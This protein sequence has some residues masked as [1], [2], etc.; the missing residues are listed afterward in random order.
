MQGAALGVVL[1][2]FVFALARMLDTGGSVIAAFLPVGLFI[3]VGIMVLN[4]IGWP[5]YSQPNFGMPNAMT[6]LRL[7]LVC[8]LSV[9]L[10]HHG[11]LVNSG[12]AIFAIAVLA[13]SLDGLDGWL[14]RRTNTATVF[15]A[16][17][18]LE[19]D[20]GLACMLSLILINGGHIGPE[21]LILGFSRYIFVAAGMA[22]PWLRAPLPDRFGR[23]AVCVFQIAT[24]CLLLLPN[25]PVLPSRAMAFCA[26]GLLL[27]SFGRDILYL[28][29]CR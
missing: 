23:K 11:I 2:G 14:A 16:R 3:A 9:A 6:L 7:A 10:V 5:R 25:L 20:A 4:A 19:V 26:A 21:A 28:A 24:L 8:A 13:L 15:G 27:W 22:L 1:A 29:R 17:F 18:D 12:V